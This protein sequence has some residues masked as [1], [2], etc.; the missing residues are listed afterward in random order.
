MLFE[1][2]EDALQWYESQERVL[3]P[4]FLNT[5]PWDEVKNH[6]VDDAFLPTLMYMRDVE[7]FTGVYFEELMKT[8]TG[9]ES[10]IRRFMERWRTEEPVHGDLLNRFMAEAGYPAEE[11]W[12]ER[13]RREIPKR[14][15]V[16][17]RINGA[18]AN[19]IGKR[20]TAVHMTWGAINE[21][22]TLTGYQR[23]WTLAKHPVLEYILKA[24]AREEA[25]HSLFYWSVA[26]IHLA[27]SD[28]SKKMARF[29]VDRFWTPVGQG[30]K[31]ESA[32]NAVV[33][34]LFNGEDGL[35]MFD[36]Q[37]T[38]RI[39]QLPGFEDFTKTTHRIQS[40]T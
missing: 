39:R 29:L 37:V 13:I 22:S 25:R 33:R 21:L 4:E 38:E 20:F 8:P 23:L 14:Y 5:I 6:S 34:C 35:A 24:I 11:K 31:P 12:Y 9:K 15:R 26:R 16:N 32:A 19:L 17:T 10:T 18:I 3:T 27:Q 2:A 40:V 7:N 28:A 36:R 30:T 1:R